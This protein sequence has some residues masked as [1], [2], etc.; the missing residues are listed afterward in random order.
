MVSKLCF[1]QFLNIMTDTGNYHEG[2]VGSRRFLHKAVDSAV[3]VNPSKVPFYLPA[4]TAIP[5][6]SKLLFGNTQLVID[7]S[8]YTWNNTAFS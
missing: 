5:L 1:P 3:I 7:P 4:L 8:V 2:F 6:F